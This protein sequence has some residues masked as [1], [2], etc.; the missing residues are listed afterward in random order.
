MGGSYGGY[1]TLVGLTFTPDVFACGVDIVGP[2]NL[3]TLLSTIRRT[4]ARS[5]A[6]FTTRVGDDSTEEGRKLLIERSPLTFAR[7]DQEAAADRPGRERPAREAGRGGPDRQGD[8]GEEHSGDVRA[9]PDEGHG[10]A[11]PQ[12]NLSFQRGGRGVPREAPRRPSR[13]GGRR[14]ERV[15]DH[16]AERRGTVAGV[17]AALETAAAQR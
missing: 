14:L 3:V 4:G 5:S 2:S 13:A 8:A 17:A 1:A 12:N 11:R 15:V 6:C 10:F 9:L 16:G 7:P